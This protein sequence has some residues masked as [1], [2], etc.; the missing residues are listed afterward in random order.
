MCMCINGYVCACVCVCVCLCVVMDVCV[1]S[2]GYL[3]K[4]RIMDSDLVG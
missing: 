4:T 1:C 2:N 3:T